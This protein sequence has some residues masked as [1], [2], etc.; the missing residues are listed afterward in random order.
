MFDVIKQFFI[1]GLMSFG[2]PAAHIGYFHKQFVIDQKWLSEEEFASIVAISHLLPGPGSSQ[3]GFA[4]G[5][6]RAGLIGA[7]S[8]FVG[9]TLPSFVLMIALAYFGN[10]FNDNAILNGVIHGLKLLAVIVV[11]DAIWGMFNNFC[12][13]KLT[14]ALCIATAI[15]ILLFQSISVQML[16]IVATGIIGYRY[17][18]ESKNTTQNQYKLALNLP[19]L[20]VTTV[21][22]GASFLVYQQELLS[23][24]FSYFQAGSLVY[25]GGHVVLPLLQNLTQDVLDSDTFLTGYALAQGVPGP[26]FTLATFLGYNTTNE[27]PLL[28]ATLATLGIFLPGFLLLCCFKSSWSAVS[29]NPTLK[30][31]TA[32]INASVVGLLIA[33][34]YQPIFTSAVSNASDFA[35]ILV[36]LLALK[37]QKLSILKLIVVVLISNFLLMQLPV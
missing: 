31:I 8:A 2:G 4:I 35:V 28:G 1:L 3:V 25:G 13:N 9:F 17:L 30:G 23:V 34:F 19:V 12:K 11:A 6:H 10:A 37:S 29:S 21:L 26:M 32:G 36:G 27:M 15:A 20:A 5:Y 24:F 33:A 22:F 18:S 16:A 7:I 14:Q